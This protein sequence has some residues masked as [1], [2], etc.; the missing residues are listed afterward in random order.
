MAGRRRVV[1]ASL[2]TG[3]RST[4]VT[5]FG[6]SSPPPVHSG[7]KQRD[8]IKKERREEEIPGGGLGGGDKS[9]LERC[10]GRGRV[11]PKRLSL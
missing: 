1:W 6:P 2:S 10:T 7:N 11:F 8:S 3:V 4:K 5:V 9:S